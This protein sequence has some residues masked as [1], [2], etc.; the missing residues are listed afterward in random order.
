MHHVLFSIKW[1]KIA[2]HIRHEVADSPR[3]S[4]FIP[5]TK[6]FYSLEKPA[7]IM[8]VGYPT[9]HKYNSVLTAGKYRSMAEDTQI[10]RICEMKRNEVGRSKNTAKSVVFGAI[11]ELDP[12]WSREILFFQKIPCSKRLP[13]Q[14]QARSTKYSNHAFQIQ[15]SRSS[16]DL[17]SIRLVPLYNYLNISSTI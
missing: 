4:L 8:M 10:E 3:Q 15:I 12:E 5:A 16:S 6:S 9:R 1:A 13:H 2:A 14:A 17:T 7:D 11:E